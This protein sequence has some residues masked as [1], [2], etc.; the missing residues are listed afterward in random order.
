MKNLLLIIVLVFS[1]LLSGIELFYDD[2]EDG[3]SNWDVVNNGGT[4]DW[5]LFEEPY[6][7]VYTLPAT[8]NG[9]VCAADA[10]APGFGFTIDSYLVLAA[11]INMAIYDDII[12]EF[13]SD[14]N[15]LDADDYCYVDVSV[16]GNN[17]NNV[18]TYP[19]IDVR[20]T[21]ESIDISN[22]ASLESI[23]I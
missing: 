17:W 20:E 18:L 3:L 4:I 1:A 21:H 9:N 2:F 5:M 7:N 22:I 12:L 23:C 6:P 15:S 8:S 13:D 16:D 19:G 14:F 10:D 11:P